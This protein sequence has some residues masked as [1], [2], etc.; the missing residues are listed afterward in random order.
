MWYT[1]TQETTI[2]HLKIVPGASQSVVVGVLGNRLKI[3]IAAPPE[4]GKANQA[5]IEFLAKKLAVPKQSIS[6]SFGQVSPEKNVRIDTFIDPE[7][8]L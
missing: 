7:Q 8:L 4:S 3:R 2:L 1:V 6:I 5:L